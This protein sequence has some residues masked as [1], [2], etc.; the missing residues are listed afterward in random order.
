MSKKKKVVEEVSDDEP[1]IEVE[2]KRFHQSGRFYENE[3]PEIETHVLVKV[4]KIDDKSGAYVSL[5]EYDGR[6][7]MINLSEISKRRIRSMTKILRIGSTEVCLVASVDEDKG[8]INL[9]KKRVDS[10]DV[11]PKHEQF[12][13][14]KTVHMIMQH[15]AQ[16]NEIQVEE[17][18]TKVS[19]PLHTKF[20][21]AYDAFKQHVNGETNIWDV[22]DFS[23]P[24]E[25]L[26]GMAEKL[27]ADIE[28]NIRR[29]LT[30]NIVRLQAKVEVTCSEY[31]GIEAVKEALTEGFKASTKECEVNIKLIAHPLFA[32]TCVCREKETGV[33]ILEEALKKIDAAITEKGG[34]FEL[35]SKPDISQ[36]EDKNQ[37]DD[38]SSDSQEDSDQEDMG[39]LDE[40]TKKQL[41]SI[42][43]DKS[44]DDEEGDGKDKKEDKK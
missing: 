19:W 20:R 35:R 33:G 24:G 27:K 37:E 21:D 2:Y 8:Y 34:G 31:D 23:Q 28:V 14:A 9:S 32:L 5:L 29:R 30:E 11:A 38:A 1:E 25:D 13:R 43:V 26:S 36:K 42:Q 17:L 39:D 41:D 22:C 7:A 18:C 12:A 3:F 10:V 44:D 16:L 15:V 40:E 4:L 6:E